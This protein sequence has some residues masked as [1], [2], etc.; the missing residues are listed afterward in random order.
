MKQFFIIILSFLILISCRVNWLGGDEKQKTD[1][2]PI[3]TEKI[4]I[5]FEVPCKVIESNGDNVIIEYQQTTFSAT[6]DFVVQID[7]LVRTKL[8]FNETDPIASNWKLISVEIIDFW[9]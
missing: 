8:I 6:I 3:V 2:D 5:N 9:F 7:D 4:E 1:S